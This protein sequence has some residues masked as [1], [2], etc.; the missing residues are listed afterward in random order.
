MP[1]RKKEAKE[2]PLM[3]VRSANGKSN[4]MG[5][6][7]RGGSR[8]S[9]RGMTPARGKQIQRS[10]SGKSQREVRQKMQA[11]LVDLNNHQYQ[12]PSKMTVGEWLETLG[13][14]IFDWNQAPHETELH[15]AYP[16][17]HPSCA[18]EPEA[19]GPERTGDSEILQPAA[20]GRRKNSLP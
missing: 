7:I 15:A 13:A 14:G 16:Q 4:G 17:P 11:A 18:W 6:P 9:P 3:A 2:A 8:G 20:S 1:W 19:A 12:K 5:T 10:F